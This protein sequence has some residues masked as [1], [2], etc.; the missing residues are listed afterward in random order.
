MNTIYKILFVALV[1][2]IPVTSIV[3][4]V[5]V[6]FRPPDFYAYEFQKIQ[7]DDE[8]MG[9]ISEQD[10]AEFFS[11]FMW[12]KEKTFSYNPSTEAQDAGLFTINEQIIMEEVRRNVNR[13]T[14]VGG[15]AVLTVL[16]VCLYFRN[17]KEKQLLREAYKYSI[18]FYGIFGTAIGILLELN[19]ITDF[20]WI[21]SEAFRGDD[22]LS[23]IVTE[24]FVR[25]AFWVGIGISALLMGIIAYVIWK[26]SKPRRMF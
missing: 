14:L 5:N 8:V 15:V 23:K 25:D 1:I 7:N 20:H 12:G 22:I 18:I 9:K 3:T 19:Q 21:S 10:V 2:C 13:I 6:I 24:V 26:I 16:G 11:D 4:A 17:T